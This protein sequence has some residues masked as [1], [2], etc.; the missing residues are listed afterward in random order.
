ML[1]TDS[2]SNAQ[3]QRTSGEVI[4]LE[5]RAGSNFVALTATIPPCDREGSDGVVGYVTGPGAFAPSES[6]PKG[7]GV[8]NQTTGFSREQPIV[9]PFR[10]SFQDFAQELGVAA[11]PPGDYVLSIEC[12]ETGFLDVIQTYRAALTFTSSTAY[13][14][15]SP[16]APPNGVTPGAAGG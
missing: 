8:G 5:P 12:V 9:L 13:V 16:L 15:T 6:R 10:G 3:P 2:V 4:A 1:V 14:V 11:V 7:V